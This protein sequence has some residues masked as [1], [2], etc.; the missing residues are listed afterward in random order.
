MKSLVVLAALSLGAAPAMAA[1]DHAA[2]QD[3]GGR[4]ASATFVPL[5][6]VLTVVSL[7]AAGVGVLVSATGHHAA[8]SNLMAGT[9]DTFCYT[10]GFTSHAIQGRR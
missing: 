7:P 5:A 6:A 10:T 4:L 2:Y 3:H 9:S 1:C 8:G